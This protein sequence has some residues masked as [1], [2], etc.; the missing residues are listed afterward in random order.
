MALGE[1]MVSGPSLHSTMHQ[2]NN[3]YHG[4]AAA[5][6]IQLWQWSIPTLRRPEDHLGSPPNPYCLVAFRCKWFSTRSRILESWIT[7]ADPHGEP[8]TCATAW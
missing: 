5:D 7:S 4:S 1:T 8:E 6:G 2:V 3:K